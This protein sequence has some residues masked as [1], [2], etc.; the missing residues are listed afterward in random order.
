[1]ID[2]GPLGNYMKSNCDNMVI[3]T[4]VKIANLFLHT[5]I[6]SKHYSLTESRQNLIDILILIIVT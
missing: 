3:V 4:F 1:M 6:H 5:E 2:W